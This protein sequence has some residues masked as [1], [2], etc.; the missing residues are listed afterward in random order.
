MAMDY[1]ERAFI[2]LPAAKM[3]HWEFSSPEAAEQ[4]LLHHRQHLA[5]AAVQL[6]L[7][8]NWST[9]N[10]AQAN[11]MFEAINSYHA[12]EKIKKSLQLMWDAIV[13]VR[14]AYYGVSSDQ[15]YCFEV[16]QHLAPKPLSTPSKVSQEGLNLKQFE[17]LMTYLVKTENNDL[18]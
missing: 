15:S 2:S 9:M 1:A 4:E 7:S 8:C 14:N 16:L 17:Q 6:F 5:P 18:R 12:G 13:M 3:A 11:L 10:L